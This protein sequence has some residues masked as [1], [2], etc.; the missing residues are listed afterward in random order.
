[1]KRERERE[2][3][4]GRGGIEIVR[5]RG[6]CAI[7]ESDVWMLGCQSWAR[8]YSSNARLALPRLAWYFWERERRVSRA[9]Q[10]QAQSLPLYLLLRP[11]SLRI[12]FLFLAAARTT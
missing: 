6:K 3:E 10:R 2:K 9:R 5:E 8:G 11:P 7:R 12:P 1:M 4:R